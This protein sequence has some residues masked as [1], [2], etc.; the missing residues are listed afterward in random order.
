MIRNMNPIGV[1]SAMR[2]REHPLRRCDKTNEAPRPAQLSA[3]SRVMN[4]HVPIHGTKK[5][6]CRS[7]QVSPLFFLIQSVQI[8]VALIAICLWPSAAGATEYLLSPGDTL[9]LNVIGVPELR[10]RAGVGTD[11]L[12]SLPLVG[13][14]KAAGR[15][16]QDVRTEVQAALTRQPFRRPA[17][18]ET[19]SASV[20]NIAP[21]EISLRIAEFRPVYVSGDVAHPGQVTYQPGLTVRQAVAMA[22][23]YERDRTETGLI[24]LETKYDQATLDFARYSLKVQRIESELGQPHGSDKPQVVPGVPSS[25]IS[26]IAA[27]EEERRLAN[28][29]AFKSKQD[30]LNVALEQSSHRIDALLTQEENE[31]KGAELDAAEASTVDDLFHKGVV[32]ASRRTEVRRSSLLSSSR[33]LETRVAV[34]GAKRDRS[35][36][37]GKLESL[38]HDRKVELLLD[39]DSASSNMRNA[40]LEMRGIKQ[41]LALEGDVQAGI[42][43]LIFRQ[44]T[45]VP[46]R[47]V[48]DEDSELLPGDTL[49]LA[50]IRRA[51]PEPGG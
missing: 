49:D 21:A 24:D 33:A 45:D 10:Q 30:S 27:E 13:D 23:G 19:G 6:G 29:E 4:L 46:R 2:D 14:I 17:S 40:T 5:W 22:G 36:F 37:Q 25:T 3:K 41:K 9:E 26:A 38:G 47:I 35:D 8:A 31:Q 15:T 44:G 18:P 28:E 12:I 32:P 50:I 7:A 16:L 34:E 39:L 48:A 20:Y 43:V 11:G 1:I 42:Y 51:K